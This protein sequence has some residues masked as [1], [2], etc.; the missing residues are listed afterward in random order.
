MPDVASERRTVLRYADLHVGI[1]KPQ[2]ALGQR[3]DVRRRAGQLAA[4]RP[5][6]LSAHIL[7]RDDQT[8]RTLRRDQPDHEVTLEQVCDKLIIYGTPDK[9]A[10]EILAFRDQIGDFGTLLYA[11]K[12]WQD[13]ELGRRSMILLAEKVL[14]RAN[15]AIG[16]T[17]AAE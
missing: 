2:P 11:G 9:V 8:V 16:K 14:P 5:D 12:D 1:P 13:R 17:E 15:A 7:G 4:E 10:D 3:V 6:R